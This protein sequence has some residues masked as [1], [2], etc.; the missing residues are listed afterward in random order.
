MGERK[1]AADVERV[2][3]GDGDALQRLILHYHA[4]L[5]GAVAAALPDEYAGRIDPD[6]VLQQAY[7]VAF[8][9]LAGCRFDGPGGFY[10]WLEKIAISRLRDQQ[11]A[12]RR[13]KRDAAREVV[14][15][16]GSPSAS[17]PD[18]LNRLEG[19]EAT[20]SRHVARNEA[21]AALMTCLARLGEEQRAVIRLRFLEGRS[22]AEVAERLG[23]TEG[24]VHMLCHRALKALREQLV[25][26]THLL[27][28]M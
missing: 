14:A 28:G 16:N 10:K 15:T 12:L 11:R 6:D 3:A 13:Q 20:P 2:M 27:S 21:V 24:A 7:V 26:I 5:R 25:S 1:R 19:T 22:V 4:P 23:K 8:Q 9:S 17:Y 18:L